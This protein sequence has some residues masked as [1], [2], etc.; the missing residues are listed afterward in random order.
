M[1]LM[2][3]AYTISHVAGKD[4]ATADVLSRAPVSHTAE[5]LQEE[6]INLS[7]DSVVASLPATEKRLREIQRHQENDSTLHHLKKFCVEG[8]PDNFSIL[9]LF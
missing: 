7:V 5:G 4:I 9:F 6:E 2:R 1:R 8:W 3:F